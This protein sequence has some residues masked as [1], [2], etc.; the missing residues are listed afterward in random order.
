MWQGIH[1]YI[2]TVNFFYYLT[3]TLLYKVINHTLIHPESTYKST[4]IA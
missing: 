3:L 4:N 2:T 1:D